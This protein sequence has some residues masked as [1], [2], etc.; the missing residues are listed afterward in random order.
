M[1]QHQQ[2]TRII[3]E[4]QRV[5][6]R[7]EKEHA[8]QHQQCQEQSKL[9][10]KLERVEH[11][12]DKQHH[13]LSKGVDELL[14]TMDNNS[15][16]C[17]N[18]SSLSDGTVANDGI[19]TTPGI[20][21]VTNNPSQFPSSPL[22]SLASLATHT[23]ETQTGSFIPSHNW[24]VVP[25]TVMPSV[26]PALTIHSSAASP[27]EPIYS[28]S[29]PMPS[30]AAASALSPT[31]PLSLAVE[32]ALPPASSV[33]LSSLA[34]TALC[35]QDQQSAPCFFPS[36]PIANSISQ[37]AP[38][39]PPHYTTTTTVPVSER[40]IMVPSKKADRKKQMKQQQLLQ[41]QQ[42]QQIQLEQQQQLQQQ[43]QKGSTP[44]SM[45]SSS[46][47]YSSSSS[48]SNV[49]TSV[50]TSSSSGGCS[51]SNVVAPAGSKPRADNKRSVPI[52]CDCGMPHPTNPV[53]SLSSIMS[54]DLL[55]QHK[56]SGGLF[57]QQNNVVPSSGVANVP[58][59]KPEVRHYLVQQPQ[60][61][62][63]Q[64]QQEQHLQSN[65]NANKTAPMNVACSRSFSSVIP[66]KSP[67]PN[68]PHPN[69]Q[70]CGLQSCVQQP[71]Q[72]EQSHQQSGVQVG[73][74]PTAVQVG[75]LQSAVQP[76]PY[77]QPAQQLVSN[78]KNKKQPRN[79]S[80]HE[81]RLQQAQQQLLQHQ[82]QQI[83][84]RNLLQQKQ[85]QLLAQQQQQQ[86]LE[87]QLHAAQVLANNHNVDG[88]GALVYNNSLTSVTALSHDGGVACASGTCSLA[89]PGAMH[90]GL[91]TA[92]VHTG[93]IN[94]ADS[95]LL[96]A[97]PATPAKVLSPHMAQVPDLVSPQVSHEIVLYVL[98]CNVCCLG[99]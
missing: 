81:T 88:T 98:K 4:L 90:P 46:A 85:Q 10:E 48:C 26:V 33:T 57:Q 37:T 63:A 18:N 36:S 29:Q 73:A 67:Q 70:A 23:V 95:T 87:Q 69:V 39:P 96:V 14:F 75:A 2:Q 38:P 44:V 17:S 61:Q 24:M 40:K 12:I 11:M 60:Q 72:G 1:Q 51:T 55:L 30:L 43:Q 21:S 71:C 45:K 62:Q 52:D 15:N 5:E 64:L 22:H 84:N 35:H 27:S 82:Q 79:V 68:L 97:A 91:S 99:V 32:G 3:K 7:L 83:H 28:P 59:M 25:G 94:V 47:C 86:H 42:Q 54:D 9:V 65:N 92:Y 49:S 50:V 78:K 34:S 53:S 13:A 80:K 16:S 6:Q 66:G 76:N 8:K 31:L 19:I 58:Q 56:I 93:G 77:S 41:Q 74:L 89:A 20:D